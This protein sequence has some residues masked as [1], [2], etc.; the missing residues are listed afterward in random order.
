[1]IIEG[2][3]IKLRPITQDDIE[4]FLEWFN[5]PEIVRYLTVYLP[6]TRLGEEEWI[7][8]V[9][10]KQ[11]PVFTITIRPKTG[12]IRDTPIGNCGFHDIDH[13]NQKAT[14]G[15][16]VGEKL[17]WGR[18]YGTEALKLLIQYGFNYL[19]MNRISSSAIVANTGSIKAH[20]K[21]GFKKEG[22]ARQAYWCPDGYY[23]DAVMFSILRKD[24]RKNNK[25]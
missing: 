23:S 24:W 8:Q 16:V 4:C 10:E 5:D 11:Q 22:F 6:M 3:N 1:M 12:P 15:L 21:A 14:L 20:E 17:E 19:N 2:E 18:G 9:M 13:R 7:K 25:K